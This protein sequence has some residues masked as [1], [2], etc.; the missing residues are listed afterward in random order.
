LSSAAEDVVAQPE[1]PSPNSKMSGFGQKEKF[2]STLI[3]VPP[4]KLTI[5]E[6]IE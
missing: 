2:K 4:K 6:K 3:K 1:E 5:E